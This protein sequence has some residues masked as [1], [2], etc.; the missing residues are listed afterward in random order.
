MRI[1]FN[2]SCLVEKGLVMLSCLVEKGLAYWLYR[3][4]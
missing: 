1:T 3:V 4:T 2:I